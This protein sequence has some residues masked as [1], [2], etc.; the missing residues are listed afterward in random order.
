MVESQ[1]VVG[2][3]RERQPL[4]GL[5]VFIGDRIGETN[6]RGNRKMESTLQQQSK[7]AQALYAV[8]GA[9]QKEYGKDGLYLRDIAAKDLLSAERA[10]VG[11][12]DGITVS[13]DGIATALAQRRVLQKS[14]D[15]DKEGKGG[16]AE[17]LTAAKASG[18]AEKTL[19]ISTQIDEVESQIASINKAVKDATKA[20]ADE[21]RL[22]ARDL[23]N[24]RKGCPEIANNAALDAFMA[25]GP[26]IFASPQA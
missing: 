24:H 20:A 10:K 15:G 25:F 12:V 9:F 17:Q 1:L 7:T 19:A 8:V 6:V 3:T 2:Q 26:G 21:S 18:N 22:I 5:T 4:S 13:G 11:L 16:L 14:I 23:R